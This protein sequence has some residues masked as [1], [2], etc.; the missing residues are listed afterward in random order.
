M[1]GIPTASVPQLSGAS[2][3]PTMNPNLLTAPGQA[4]QTLGGKIQRAGAVV[5]QWHDKRQKHAT[6]A[7]VAKAQLAMTEAQ[8]KLET[9]QYENPDDPEKWEEKRLEYYGNARDNV[10]LEGIGR[11]GVEAINMLFDQGNETSRIKTTAQKEKRYIDMKNSDILQYGK[12]LLRNG[13][14][15]EALGEFGK[16]TMPNHEKIP[17]IERAMSEGRYEEIYGD[18]DTAPDIADVEAIFEQLTARDKDGDYANFNDDIG[19]LELGQRTKLINIARSA[20]KKRKQNAHKSVMEAQDAIME[21]EAWEL[22]DDV[23]ENQRVAIERLSA[24]LT[25]GFNDLSPEYEELD[26]EIA[27]S[28]EKWFGIERD[29]KWFDEQWKKINGG[30]YDDEG[31]WVEEGVQFNRTARNKLVRAMID[32]ETRNIADNEEDL[33]KTL[34]DRK[35]SSNEKLVRTALR[36]RVDRALAAMEKD[37]L[38]T[39]LT[40]SSYSRVYASILDQV[41]ADADSGKMDGDKVRGYIE[42]DLAALMEKHIRPLDETRLREKMRGTQQKSKE[43]SQY[44]KGQRAVQGGVT[45]EFDGQ[46]WNPIN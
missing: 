41:R 21:G 22:A 7:A 10:T 1:Q 35:V 26:K 29:P 20:A 33:E 15:E 4:M 42:N 45:Y 13:K 23:N 8:T 31:D 36:E 25:D 2:F 27:K 19:G 6:D 43:Q 37:P 44:K 11:D 3:T 5:D 24:S 38:T 16:L 46:N 28:T 17:L 9:Y 34:F 14:R 32:A 18:I 30:Y 39:S 40:P 12:N